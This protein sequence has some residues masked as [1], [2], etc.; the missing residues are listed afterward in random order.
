MGHSLTFHFARGFA[1]GLLLGTLLGF[2]ASVCQDALGLPHLYLAFDL[3]VGAFFGLVAGWCF[4]LQTVLNKTL[5]ELFGFLSKQV[6][7]MAD[8]MASDWLT[9]LRDLFAGYSSQTKGAPKWFLGRWVLSRLSKVEP[10]LEAV[11]RM[12]SSW[13]KDHPPTPQELAFEAMT[14][15]LS[16]LDAAFAAAYALLLMGAVL[17]WSLPFLLKSLQ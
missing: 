7:W 16:P 6:P 15:L 17:F 14:I 3:W 8:A 13:K 10:F 11:L 12:K 2:L 9:R 5:K 4:A 1:L